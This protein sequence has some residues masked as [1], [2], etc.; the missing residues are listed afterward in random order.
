MVYNT[1]QGIYSFLP[2]ET[3]LLIAIVY[4]KFD[5]GVSSCLS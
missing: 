1:L 4:D 2:I 3:S 5:F